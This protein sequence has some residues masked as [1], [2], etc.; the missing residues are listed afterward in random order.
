MLFLI[1]EPVTIELGT[2]YKYQQCGST[3]RLV[4][5]KD[6]FQYVPLMKNLENF[7]MNPEI[8]EEVH[9]Y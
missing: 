4:E 3:Q 2:S 5:F 9:V 7:L 8:F 1:Q 6:T